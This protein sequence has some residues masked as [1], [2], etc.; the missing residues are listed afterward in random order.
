M[1][2]L[3]PLIL[4]RCKLEVDVNRFAKTMFA[5]ASLGGAVVM[6][7]VAVSL[8]QKNSPKENSSQVRHMP[9]TTPNADSK[10][11]L[12]GAT[13]GEQSDARP[14]A[15]YVGGVGLIEPAGESTVIGSPLPG[16]VD[17]VLV[18]PGD[19]VCAGDVLMR[20]DRRS[21]AA[22]LAVAQAELQAQRARLQEL[23]SQIS[24]L[25]ARLVAAKAIELQAA[26]TEAN[27]KKEFDRT[28]PIRNPNALSEEEIDARKLNW[29]TAKAK[30]LEASA[31]VAEA[32]ASLDMLAGIPVATSIEVQNAAILQAEANLHRA[33]T[34]FDL[35]TII[36]PKAG[37]VLSVKIR[38]GE[39]VPAAVL[40]TPFITLGVVSPLHLRVDIDES[41]IP[42]FHPG[43]KAFA[44]VRGQPQ[45]KIPIQYVRTEP[46]VIPKRSLTGTVS[47]RVDTRVLQVIYS[48]DPSELKAA[49]GQQIDVYVEESRK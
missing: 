41:E 7:L 36:A 4:P 13:A 11:T 23:Q 6:L 44:S 31:R 40:S 46:L 42:R 25:Q 17:E 49:I 18:Q 43:A 14:V 5:I 2:L 33:Q 10:S 16:V 27:A 15:N 12:V 26:A 8:I 22:D 19:Q 32:Q 3:L 48:A 35:R 20:L 38:A 34:N 45:L 29:E 30:A 39:F 21:A 9:P 28:T 24:V 37:T 1:H 47:E